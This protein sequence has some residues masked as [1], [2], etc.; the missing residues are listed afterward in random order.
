VHGLVALSAKAR[1]TRLRTARTCRAS[2]QG[3]KQTPSAKAAFATTD[4]RQ[5][6]AMFLGLKIAAARDGKADRW[7]GEHGKFEK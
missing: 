3:S 7:S 4:F 6:F 5:A 2:K 1:L